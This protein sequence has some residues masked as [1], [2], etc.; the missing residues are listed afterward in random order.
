M[1]RKTL[2]LFWEYSKPYWLKRNLALF[3]GTFSVMAESYAAPY[4]LSLFINQLE[5]GHVSFSTSLPIILLYGATLLVSTVITWRITLWATW[6]FEVHGQR[7]VSRNILAQLTRQSV[8]FHNNRFGG[9]LISQTNKLVGAFE[10][11][12]DTVIWDTIP[13]VT[14]IVTA[15]VVLWFISPVYSLIIVG[16]AVLFTLAVVFGSRFMLE[17]NK[18]E[19]AAYSR[20]TGFISDV[21]TNISTVKAFGAERAEQ[22]NGYRKQ[23]EWMNRS[24]DSLRGFLGVSTVYATI[25]VLYY[26][27]IL[28]MTVY[29]AS[30][31]SIPIGSVFLLLSYALLVGRQMW[32][33]NGIM[34]N[35]NRLMGDSH[36]MVEILNLPVEINDSNNKVL[37][38]K[39]G[40]ISFNN[41]TFAHD[42]GEGAHIFNDFSLH[43]KPGERIGLVGHSGSGKTT[44]TR[45]LLRFNDIS[46][47]EISIDSTNIVDVTQKS[48]REA[49]SYVAQE[50]MLF[51]RSLADNIA[52]GKPDASIAEIQR[53]AELAHAHEFIVTLP[54]G[55]D[56]LVGERGVKL[57]GGQRQRVA[58]ARAIL[59][60]APILVLDEATSA[61]DSESEKLIQKSLDNLMKGRTSIVIA[62]RLSTI[63]KLDRIIVLDN[64]KIVEDGTHAELLAG[65]KMYAKLWSHQSGGFIEE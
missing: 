30:K 9:A 3:F 38:T 8:N 25:L 1:Q 33:I 22:K 37:R 7:D 27:G 53:A 4:I 62:H 40:A 31:Q 26:V 52:Y 54:D 55:Y 17:R 57:S 39:S 51:H 19:V 46:S 16:M 32:G 44:L 65:N 5:A 24:L 15:S 28:L 14:G 64:G 36:D 42:E 43:I 59:K 6:T 61:L 23:H 50:P 41:I 29:I 21:V 60:N 34:R 35:Y 20:V 11:F 56:T 47:G 58:I 12:W 2:K 45:L 13:V 18:Q 10:R 49:I 48:L 63:A